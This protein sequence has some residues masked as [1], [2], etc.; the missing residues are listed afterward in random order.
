MEGAAGFARD[1]EG[2]LEEAT[3]G[4]GAALKGFRSPHPG[5]HVG[6]VWEHVRGFVHAVDW[7]ERWI[8]GLLAAQA[9]VFVAVLATRRSVR[10]QLVLFAVCGGAIYLAERL[11]ALAGVHWE[12]FASQNYFDK[13]GVFAAAMLSGPLLL[14]LV[15][16][17]VNILVLLVKDLIKLKRM[18]LRQRARER[19]SEEGK[20]VQ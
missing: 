6:A 16:I 4:L 10:A 9:A 5:G 2:M 20:K 18:E 13:Q 12:S 19:A 14:D 15:V 3:R 8:Q 11:N 7:S 1:L 17:Q